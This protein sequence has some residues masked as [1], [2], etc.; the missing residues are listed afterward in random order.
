MGTRRRWGTCHR[1]GAERLVQL[2]RLGMLGD[3]VAS[4]PFCSIFVVVPR[5]PPW[6]LARF[7][8]GEEKR[9]LGHSE[10]GGEKPRLQGLTNQACLGQGAGRESG[11]LA[12]SLAPGAVTQSRQHP[13]PPGPWLDPLGQARLCPTQDLPLQGCSGTQDR[14][15]ARRKRPPKPPRA[16][17]CRLS[18]GQR[19]RSHFHSSFWSRGVCK[20][21]EKKPRQ[22]LR[23]GG[24]QIFGSRCVLDPGA[25]Q[26]APQLLARARHGASAAAVAQGFPPL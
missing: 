18:K 7:S 22:W 10:A 12:P 9:R 20:D 6:R 15:V 16:G 23:L 1:W 25:G 8:F 19:C 2:R 17:I 21:G 11:S 26:T 3:A 14:T 13:N 24:A 5:L 4:R